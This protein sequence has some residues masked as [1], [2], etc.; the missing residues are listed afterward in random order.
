MPAIDLC[1]TLPYEDRV[2]DDVGSG[3][4]S[5][6]VNSSEH[7]DNAYL[8]TY[9]DP[10]EY[11]RNV[12]ALVSGR[13]IV[14]F[15]LR[16]SLQYHPQQSLI[17]LPYDNEDFYVQTMEKEDD[18]HEV[19]RLPS[20]ASRNPSPVLFYLENR[21]LALCACIISLVLLLVIG[22]GVF[23]VNKLFRPIVVNTTF[24]NHYDPLNLSNT[25]TVTPRW[26]T[27]TLPV[28]LL[29]QTSTMTTTTTSTAVPLIDEASVSYLTCASDRWGR[30]CENLCKPCGF[31]LCHPTT[32]DCVCPAD[33]YGEF[34]DLWKGN[35]SLVFD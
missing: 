34:C 17:N 13:S 22:L 24:N 3:T 16:W 5:S 26:I 30:Q 2:G 8:N 6:Y 35:E 7:Y 32:G 20:H 4:S 9:D 25:S 23:L 33:I 12:S 21:N 29:V 14:F 15:S 10:L 27:P 28:M 19:C 18:R 31:G 11:L 1:E